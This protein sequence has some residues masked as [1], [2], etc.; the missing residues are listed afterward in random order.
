MKKFLILTCALLVITIF[1]AVKYFSNLSVDSRKSDEILAQIP[2]DA[3]IVLEYSNDKSFY[4]IFRDYPLFEYL[5]GKDEQGKLEKIRAGFQGNARVAELLDQQKI[6]ISLHAEKDSVSLLWLAG[7]KEA[8]PQN[9]MLRFLA[10]S[11]QVEKNGNFLRIVLN[12]VKEPFYLM[13]NGTQTAGSFS[14]AL[15]EKVADQNSARISKEFISEINAGTAGSRNSILNLFINYQ[16]TAPFLG[17]FFQD[18]LS[19]NYSLLNNLSGFS[20]LNMNFKSDAMMFNGITKVDTLKQAYL[21]LFLH[22]QATSGTTMRL[23]PQSV[24][25]A[26]QFNLS[27]YARFETDLRQLFKNRKELEPLTAEINRMGTETGINPERDIRN[28]WAQ[29][30]NTFQTANHERF[31]IIKVKDGRRLGFLLEP[32]SSEVSPEIRKLSYSNLFYF[33]FGDPF[34]SFRRPYYF[35]SDN[36]VIFSNS[37]R[38]LQSY[39]N[40]YKRENFL[41]QTPRYRTFEQLVSNQANLSLFIHNGNSRSLT[42]SNLKKRFSSNFTDTKGTMRNF[43]GLSYQW[44]SDDGHFFTNLYLATV[45]EE[46]STPV[47]LSDSLLHTLG[48]GD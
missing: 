23:L 15:L 14:R 8:V 32:L 31:G 5:L 43:Y 37:L 4:E 2:A 36:L 22:Q 24:A 6:F 3:A 18:K 17:Q 46:T 12:G 26:L 16:S 21:N 39:I 7:L 38:G 42:R 33:Y 19:G 45:P 20:T 13:V 29:E 27:D 30:F 47:P 48:S 34:R 40:D 35:I 11:G 44:S 1:L 41:Y 28:T 10:R 25:N 9:K